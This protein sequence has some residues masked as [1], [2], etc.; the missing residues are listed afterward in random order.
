MDFKWPFNF[1][2]YDED[3]AV[4][5]VDVGLKWGLNLQWIDNQNFLLFTFL[6][7]CFLYLHCPCLCLSLSLSVCL[8]VCLSFA[9]KSISLLVQDLHMTYS[10]KPLLYGS[11]LVKK[12]LPNAQVIV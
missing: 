10:G 9:L 6:D 7:L 3:I 8:P 5:E 1:R 2:D 4:T 12:L 11:T